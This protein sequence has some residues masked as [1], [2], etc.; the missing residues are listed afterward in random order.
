MRACGLFL[1]MSP[2][3]VADTQDSTFFERRIR[4]LLV[5]HCYE[6]HSEA[7][8]EQ[9]GGLLLDRRSGRIKGR[10]PWQLLKNTLLYRRQPDRL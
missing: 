2:F 1:L 6:C 8:K 4:P 9:Q 5:K 10:F 7:A 3:A